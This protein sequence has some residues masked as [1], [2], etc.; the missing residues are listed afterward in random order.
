MTAHDALL[1]IPDNDRIPA[2]LGFFFKVFPDRKKKPALWAQRL[3][4]ITDRILQEPDESQRV[5]TLADL[6]DPVRGERTGT[7]SRDAA[8]AWIR[9]LPLDEKHQGTLLICLAQNEG[10]ISIHAPAAYPWLWEN[11]PRSQQ[12]EAFAKI[13]AYWASDKEWSA[14]NPDA[15]GR[16]L[17][18]QAES[19]G[20]EHAA[21]LKAFALFAV[22]RDPESG[23]A[24]ANANPDSATRAKAV[25]EVAAVIRSQWPRRA[26][27][28]GVA[29]P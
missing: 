3:E 6:L 21:A 9:S 1:A 13:V 25:E 19:L 22:A 10:C 4:A 14:K 23:L 16:W 15:C 2:K 17:N 11:V 20:P 29:S 18:T 24:W 7:A 8:A 27:E 26:E 12:Q 5:N 28:L